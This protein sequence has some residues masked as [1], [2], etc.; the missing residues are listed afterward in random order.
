MLCVLA[1][2]E[3][4]ACVVTT[5]SLTRISWMSLTL[6]G[7]PLSNRRT[8]GDSPAGAD[9]SAVAGTTD[10][11]IDIKGIPPRTVMTVVVSRMKGL[12]DLLVH[13]SVVKSRYRQSFA[14]EGAGSG[15][16][17]ILGDPSLGCGK[18]AITALLVTQRC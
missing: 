4:F 17:M 14:D 15:Q 7:F 18:E 10:I 5:R 11:M 8:I 13:K 9:E 6:P 2:A 16:I 1:G 3:D 12:A